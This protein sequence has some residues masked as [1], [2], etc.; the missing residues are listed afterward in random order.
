MY[1]SDI[2]QE[3]VKYLTK[4][5]EITKAKQKG[6]LNERGLARR[7][8]DE[9][10]VSD[11]EFTAA[12]GVIRRF[13]WQTIQSPAPALKTVSYSI[14]SDRTVL[15]YEKRQSVLKALQDTLRETEL[16]RGDT[17]KIVTGSN[18]VTA[19]IN[20]ENHDEI[21]NLQ[22]YDA[23]QDM[24]QGLAE[25][26]LRFSEEASTTTGLLGAVTQALHLHDI[27]IY[28]AM[29]SAD[30]CLCYIETSQISDVCSLIETW[31]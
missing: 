20:D 8:V 12:L 13:N 3:L 10:I 11:D 26:S 18:T 17:I 23:Y 27:T 2:K 30:E 16:Q 31:Q 9:N 15:T 7:L 4:H 22:D 24:K 1:M 21:N 28:E 6:V 25:V 14:Q 5:P 19:V 29:T